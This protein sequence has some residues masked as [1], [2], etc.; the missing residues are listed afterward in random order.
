MPACRDDCKVDWQAKD[1]K[2][3][4]FASDASKAAFLKAPDET[5]DKATDMVAAADVAH[6]GTAME[7]FSSEDATALVE[8]RIKAAAD[9][10][11]GVY[12]VE[13]RVNGTS[14]PLVYDGVDFTRT[15]KGY[16]FFPDG[17]L[18]RQGR[19]EET[20]PRRLLGGAEGRQALGRGDAH[21]QGADEGRRRLDLGAAPAET[22]VVDP[23]RRAPGRRP[24]TSAAGR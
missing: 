6:V 5:L 4:C 1:G 15:L 19:A 14:L 11:G 20:L 22:L 7:K 9:K 2:R 10:A 16:G 18:P 17:S 12:V 3:Y 8:D 13:D 23:R 21:L 24:R